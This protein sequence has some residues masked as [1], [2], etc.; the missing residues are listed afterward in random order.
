MTRL[1]LRN[2]ICGALTS[3]TAF[4]H[5]YADPVVA[6]AEISAYS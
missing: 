6:C 2:Q 4:G 3:I 5:P 1:L